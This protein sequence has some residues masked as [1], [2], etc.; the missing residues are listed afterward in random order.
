[1]TNAPVIIVLLRPN[2]SRGV[3]VYSKT[4]ILN[5]SPVEAVQTRQRTQHVQKTKY[6]LADVRIQAR[7]DGAEDGRAVVL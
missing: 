4:E 7:V 6:D 1:M 3:S 2:L 5:K